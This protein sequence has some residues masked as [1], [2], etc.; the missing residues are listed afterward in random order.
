LRCPAHLRFSD[1]MTGFHQTRRMANDVAGHRV[2][3]KPN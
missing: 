3:I 2:S 1:G